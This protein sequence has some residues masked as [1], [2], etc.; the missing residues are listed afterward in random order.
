MRTKKVLRMKKISIGLLILILTLPLIGCS[1]G[2]GGSDFIGAA[3][4][5]ISASPNQIDSQDRTRV[6]VDISRVNEEGILLKIRY[7]RG[8]TYAPSTSRLVVGSDES[9][10]EPS[11]NTEIEGDVYLVYFLSA[12]L[13]NVTSDD[14]GDSGTLT[15][16]LI[17][18]STV[19]EGS[20]EV[21]ADVD[22]P[23]VENTVEFDPNDPA[24]EAES[25]AS[26]EVS[27]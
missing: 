23:L 15:L 13:F 11:I 9:G 2:G 10:I 19:N 17:G 24:F 6:R 25:S 1:G 20:I 8:L 21:D 4:V 16:E 12:A 14:E 5:S 26:I 22:D 7:L 18:I 27:T 3:D